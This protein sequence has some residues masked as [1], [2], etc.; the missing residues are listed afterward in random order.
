[1]SGARRRTVHYLVVPWTARRRAGLLAIVLLVGLVG[2]VALAAVAAAR[3]TQATY[4]A[5]L[6]SSRASDLDLYVYQLGPGFYPLFSTSIAGTLARIPGVADVASSPSVFLMPHEPAGTPV[7][8]PINDDEVSFQGSLGRA[9]FDQDRP[10][11]V[12]GR[13]ANPANPYEIVASTE[14]ASLLHWHVGQRIALDAFSLRQVARAAASASPSPRPVH[15]FDVRLVGVVLFAN[16]VA[17]DDVDRYP[18]YIVTTP[19]LLRRYPAIAAFSSYELR[20]TNGAEGVPAVEAKIVKHLPPGSPYEFH[21]TSVVEGQVER[22]TRPESIA[23]AVFGAIAAA[24]ALLV[25][26]QAVRREIWRHRAEADVARALGADRVTLVAGIALG[27]S[28]AILVGSLLA[29]GVAVA[30]SPLAPLGPVRQVDPTPGAQLDWVVL[31]GAALFVV[32][33]V[34]LAVGLAS[35]AVTRAATR[36]AVTP[37]RSSRVADAAARTGLPVPTIAGLRFA[38]ERRA[39]QSATSSRPALVAAVVAVVVVVTTTTFASGLT[40]LDSHPALFGWNWDYGILSPNGEPV[41]PYAGTLLSHDRDVAAWAGFNFANAQIVGARGTGTTTPI[42]L[43]SPHAA[44]GPALLAGHEVDQAGQVVLGA[45]T[46]AELHRGLGQSVVVSYGFKSDYPVWVPP[47][48]V[49]VVGIATLP[50]IGGSGTLHTSMGLGAVL[51]T[52]IEPKAFRAALHQPDPNLDGPS[53][54]VVRLR[55]GVRASSGL[56]DLRRVAAAS[57]HVMQADPA[58]GGGP[59]F[60]VVG[61]QRPAEITI[62][63]SSG[64]TSAILALGLA[65]GAVVSLAFALTSSVRRRRRELAMLKTLGFTRRQLVESIASQSSVVVV[66]GILFGVPIGIALGRWLWIVFAR[67]IGAVP[68][69]TVP[70]LQVAGIAVVALVLANLVAAVPGRVAARTP[71]A[72]V[73]RSE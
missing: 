26:A 12:E 68:D 7:P 62:Y 3:R 2:G 52:G 65:A 38:L 36:R 69:A 24:A 51:A 34:A 8:A 11:V 73:L 71:A 47:T 67:Q 39:P 17:H 22:A 20:L 1:V 13:M 5:Y 33:L 49:R 42:I 18:T 21:V 50:A 48:R 27:P 31:A 54:L 14:A 64:A 56:A 41:P 15:R 37:G 32:A 45:E 43:V 23:L 53:M 58:S 40:T 30:L 25:G 4:P 46:A 16:E 6:A 19:A 66:V 72:I 63:Q 57:T 55:A 28:L 29:V 60:I 35:S 59:P 44:L 10:A 70:V 9:Y 61:A